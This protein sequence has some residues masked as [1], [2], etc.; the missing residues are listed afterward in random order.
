MVSGGNYVAKIEVNL[1]PKKTSISLL[2]IGFWTFFLSA[3]GYFVYGGLGGF[4]AIF[5]YTILMGLTIILGFIPLVGIPLQIAAMIW[6]IEPFVFNLTGIHGTLLTA[7]IFG[8]NFA[9]GIFINI[10]ITLAVMFSGSD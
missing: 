5:L 8:Y 6:L 2:P 4:L 7:F 9:I 3:L 10:F 1:L